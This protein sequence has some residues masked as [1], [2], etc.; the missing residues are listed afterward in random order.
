MVECFHARSLDS[1]RYKQADVAWE[2]SLACTSACTPQCVSKTHRMTHLKVV[3]NLVLLILAY[4]EGPQ[5][6][7]TV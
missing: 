2:R 5:A 7:S 3:N 1:L 6:V 4:C